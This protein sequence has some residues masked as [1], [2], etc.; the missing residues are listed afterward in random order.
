MS[1]EART[2]KIHKIT[3][4]IVDHDDLGARSC[5]DVLENARYPNHCIG[6]HVM[7]TET[8]EVEW[9]DEHPLNRRDT[10]EQAFAELF[11][12]DVDDAYE[13]GFEAGWHK[14]TSDR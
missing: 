9:T 6:P 4:F 8:R 14:A 5:K 7:S 13:A 12:R 11:K 1:D 10:Q 2:T 3:L